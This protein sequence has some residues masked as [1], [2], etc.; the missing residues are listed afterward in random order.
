ME[1]GGSTETLLGMSPSEFAPTLDDFL[2]RVDPSDVDSVKAAFQ[3]LSSPSGPSVIGVNCGFVLPNGSIEDRHLEAWRLRE[4]GEVVGIIAGDRQVDEP[5]TGDVRPSE[6]ATESIVR[7]LR[8]QI[9]NPLAAV[10]GRA[11]L[12]IR[13]DQIQ[14]DSALRQSVETI[15]FESERIKRYVQQLQSFDGLQ[16]LTDPLPGES[17]LD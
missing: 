9:N 6:T 1:W 14:A 5:A 15:L 13:E 11:Q 3:T 16:R 2:K 4:Q 10:I 17:F 7:A 12:L 8:H